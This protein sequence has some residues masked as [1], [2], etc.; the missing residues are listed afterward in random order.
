[1]A[2]DPA[3]YTYEDWLMDTDDGIERCV[4]GVDTDQVCEDCS[5]QSVPSDLSPTGWA[6]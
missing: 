5:P 4:H 3:D 1:M 2:Y 6:N